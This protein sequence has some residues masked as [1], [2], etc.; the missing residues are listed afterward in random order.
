MVLS[1]CSPKTFCYFLSYEKLKIDVLCVNSD[2]RISSGRWQE[3]IVAHYFPVSIK[4][5]KLGIGIQKIKS[6]GCLKQ[7]V[8]NN[9]QFLSKFG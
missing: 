3:M 2:I 4:L 7:S 6:G 5:I 9:G 1:P 8:A